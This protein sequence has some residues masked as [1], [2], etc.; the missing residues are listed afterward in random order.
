MNIEQRSTNK[1][2]RS[3][4]REDSVEMVAPSTRRSVSC[5][6]QLRPLDRSQGHL[7]LESKAMVAP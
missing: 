1:L 4:G 2:V 7:R 6:H 5:T 3:S